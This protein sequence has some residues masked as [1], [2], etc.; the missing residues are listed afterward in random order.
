MTSPDGVIT[1]RTH[2]EMMQQWVPELDFGP[3]GDENQKPWM[4]YF[5]A[6]DHSAS[7]LHSRNP[8]R[9]MSFEYD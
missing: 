8:S 4:I 7:E 2:I 9:L 5:C 6:A 1:T 3:R